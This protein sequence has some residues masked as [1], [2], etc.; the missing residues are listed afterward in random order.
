MSDSNLN[1]SEKIAEERSRNAGQTQ[2]THLQNQIDELRRLLRDQT[3]KYQLAVEHIR[4][5]EGEVAE[6]TNQ[7]ARNAQE[8]NQTVE[9]FRR[10]ITTLRK[11]FASTL[12]KIDEGVRP[13][14]DM[15]AQIQELAEARK[16]D[17]VTVAS[18]INR[19]NETEQK[20]GALFAL[21][22]ESDE[23]YRS[24]LSRMDTFQTAEDTRRVEL[25]KILEEVQIE[26]QQLRRQSAENQQLVADSKLLI[27]EQQSR[28]L[29][30]DDFRSQ[31]D[32]VVNEIPEQ[33]VVISNRIAE[34]MQETKQIERTSTDRFLSNQQRIE[35]IRLQQDEKITSLQEMEDRQLRQITTWIERVDSYVR[36]LEQ[37]IT[38]TSNRLENMQH[39]HATHFADI[40]TR[41][42]ELLANLTKSLTSMLERIKTERFTVTDPDGKT[43]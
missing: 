34:L 14:R 8:L 5:T 33:L 4:K 36:D 24:V 29:R 20:I 30:V 23:R 16:T 18:L 17:R 37:R 25:R 39:D 41:E 15:Q 42:M 35:E 22:R 31:I 9:G 38:R 6:L 10:E 28:L 3:Q 1:I 19:L 7:F 11:E 32:K 26:K 43:R 12:V 21:V 27:S 40:D 13:I 2:M